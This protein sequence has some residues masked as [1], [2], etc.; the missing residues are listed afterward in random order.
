YLVDGERVLVRERDESVEASEEEVEELRH[1]VVPEARE[2][3]FE[4]AEDL[5]AR[6]SPS[7][8]GGRG[9]R[10][11]EPPVEPVDQPPLPGEEADFSVPPPATGAEIVGVEER[12]GVRYYAIRDLRNG[13]IVR[14]VTRFSARHLWYYAISEREE[15]AFDPDEVEWDGDLGIWHAYTR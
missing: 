14:N 12:E 9:S 13:N 15:H 3:A 7:G 2:R 6:A 4:P 10:M 8:R 5:P 11:P 1:K